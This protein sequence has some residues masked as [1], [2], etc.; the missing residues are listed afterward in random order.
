M[1]YQHFLFTVTALLSTF[2]PI[3]SSWCLDH[4]HGFQANCHAIFFPG[5]LHWLL[6]WDPNPK[7]TGEVLR[8]RWTATGCMSSFEQIQIS[9]FGTDRLGICIDS[10]WSV[11][12]SM[13]SRSQGLSSSLPGSAPREGKKRDSAGNKIKEHVEYSEKND[14]IVLQ[15][16]YFRS[17]PAKGLV[18]PKIKTRY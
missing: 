4:A 17:L 7:A 16:T 18:P 6:A 13:Q 3:K 12:R 1:E 11:C 2:E 10:V 15:K 8:P 9:N 14:S 5:L